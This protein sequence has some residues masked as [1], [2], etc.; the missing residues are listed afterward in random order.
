MSLQSFLSQKRAQSLKIGLVP[1]M[2]ALHQGHLSLI[3]HCKQHCDLT[4]VSV[5]VNPTQFH[6]P[7]DYEKY[8]VDLDQDLELLREEEVEVIFT[9][10]K[11]VLYPV[12]SKISFSFDPLDSILEGAFRPGH[13]S[14][15]ALVVS[16]LFNIVQPDIAC[17]G[18]K[19]LQ[20]VAVIKNLNAELAFGIDIQ[21]IPTV[22]EA[23]GLALSSRNTRLSPE[24]RK[25][26]PVLYKTMVETKEKL[27]LGES[28]N[29]TLSASRQFLKDHEP[30]IQLEYFELVDSNNLSTVRNLS[31]HNQVS[32][33]TAAYFGE[34]RLIDN[35]FVISQ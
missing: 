25:L 22:R 9:P 13:F 20:Q 15:V 6:N 5:F 2:G 7:S 23:D 11:E 34:V 30:A 26:A 12:E 19:D 8:P 21:T 28:L 17:F 31:A 24:Q 16:K 32:L 18:Q 35:L 4:V 1:T 27:L 10:K 29:T 3:R 14:G 33:C